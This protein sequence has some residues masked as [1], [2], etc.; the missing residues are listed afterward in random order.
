MT[1]NYIDFR[2]ENGL[3]VAGLGKNYDIYLSVELTFNYV[4]ENEL[5]KTKN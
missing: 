5:D 4:L 2:V 1:L 3:H